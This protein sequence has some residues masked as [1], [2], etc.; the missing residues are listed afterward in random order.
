MP[1][2][3]R[4]ALALHPGDERTLNELGAALENSGDWQQAAEDLYAGHRCASQTCNA[5]FNLARLQLKHDQASAAEQQFRTMLAQ[6]PFRRERCIAGLELHWRVRANRRPRRLSF[7]PRCSL[8]PTISPHFTT[9]EI[10]RFRQIS[11]SRLW[12]FLKPPS[13]SAQGCGRARTTGGR[14]CVIGTRRRRSGQLREAI[15]LSPDNPDLHSLLSQALASTGQLQQAIAERK[16]RCICGQTTPMT[17]TTWAFWKARAGKIAEARED[18]RHRLTARSRSCA[19]AGKSGASS[20]EPPS[21]NGNPTL[22][23]VIP[24]G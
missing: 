14:L 7:A 6:C 21:S 9:W 18:F 12:S 23:F 2:R 4:H 24:S 3:F 11:L 17:G 10:W 20:G 15:A 1:S 19:G 13:N 8:D 22:P 16:Q 5:R